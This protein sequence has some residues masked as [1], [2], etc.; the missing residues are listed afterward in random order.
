MVTERFRHGNRFIRVRHAVCAETVLCAI[1]DSG[2]GD[3]AAILNNQWGATAGM[4]HLIAHLDAG[5]PGAVV[6]S[7]GCSLA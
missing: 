7:L 5:I 1:V 4:N 3:I 6:C 2:E